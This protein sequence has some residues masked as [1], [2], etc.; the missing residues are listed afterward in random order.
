[1]Q[2]P[3]SQDFKRFNDITGPVFAPH[4]GIHQQFDSDGEIWAHIFC[5]DFW[6]P[7]PNLRQK[8]LFNDLCAANPSQQNGKQGFF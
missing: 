1:M 8:R 5:S 6:F 2:A 4:I 3:Q 7:G